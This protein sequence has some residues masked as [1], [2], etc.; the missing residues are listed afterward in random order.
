MI[1]RQEKFFSEFRMGPAASERGL[2]DIDSLSGPEMDQDKWTRKSQ[3][4][5]NGMF[6]H[7]EINPF[8]S[9]MVKY[10]ISI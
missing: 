7:G 6:W 10:E 4:D 2:C 1:H 8:I 9:Q 3:K 5:I